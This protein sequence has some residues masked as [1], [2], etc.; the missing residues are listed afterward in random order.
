M[1]DAKDALKHLIEGDSI[2]VNGE[3]CTREPLIRL[4][5]FMRYPSLGKGAGRG[6]GNGSML[7][8][9][10]IDLYEHIDGAVRAKLNEW[11][12]PHEGDLEDMIRQLHTA[13]GDQHWLSP[14]D[15][16]R[17]YYAF[18]TWRTQI[19]ELIDPPHVWEFAGACPACEATHHE[20]GDV[21]NLALFAKLKPGTAVIPECRACGAMWVGEGRLVELGQAIGAD[22]DIVAM[23]ELTGKGSANA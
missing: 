2:E 6:G 13:V 17:E 22:V 12:R 16:D 15:L 23:R 21:R 11:R 1:E 3:T 4:L 8:T 10:A 20:D 7:N 5:R 14:D 19:E 18:V 9:A